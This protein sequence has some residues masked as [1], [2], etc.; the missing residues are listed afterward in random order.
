LALIIEKRFT[1]SQNRVGMPGLA[2]YL[3][4]ARPWTFWH[5]LMI[6]WANQRGNTRRSVLGQPIRVLFVPP[7]TPMASFGHPDVDPRNTAPILLAFQ[8]RRCVCSGA[9]PAAMAISRSWTGCGRYC[10]H[11]NLSI[12][13]SIAISLLYEGAP[14]VGTYGPYSS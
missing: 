8:A 1:K 6:I 2:T 5:I 12:V 3:I 14:L 11:C 10:K 9:G 4:A 7:G 13:R